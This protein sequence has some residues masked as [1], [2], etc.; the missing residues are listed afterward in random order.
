MLIP[1][2]WPKMSEIMWLT[3]FSRTFFQPGQAQKWYSIKTKFHIFVDNGWWHRIHVCSV[4]KLCMIIT[5]LKSKMT[6]HFYMCHPTFI[7]YSTA[8]KRINNNFKH[9]V[10]RKSVAIGE[11]CV[12]IGTCTCIFHF[13][14]LK[15]ISTKI[16]LN[17]HSHHHHRKCKTNSALPLRIPLFPLA[18]SQ[19][20]RVFLKIEINATPQKKEEKAV[21]SKS[22]LIRNNPC[23]F[24]QFLSTI[25]QQKMMKT[26]K[27]GQ[28]WKRER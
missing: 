13:Y 19:I 16:M 15:T 25:F 14:N 12:I 3:K 8:M 10:L 28:H 5:W 23:V 22:L 11:L 9:W 20:P 27:M 1:I 24:V 6:T 7:L 17:H 21:G 18:G 4:N 26:K 2:E